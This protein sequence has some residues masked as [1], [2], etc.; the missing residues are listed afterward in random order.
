MTVV[1]HDCCADARTHTHTPA[2]ANLCI[3]HSSATNTAIDLTG[4]SDI[5]RVLEL[6]SSG[7]AARIGYLGPLRA[8]SAP[9]I[10][11]AG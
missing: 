3:A 2:F 1:L 4:E 11:T 9:A 10:S 6:P 7:K 5:E 8:A